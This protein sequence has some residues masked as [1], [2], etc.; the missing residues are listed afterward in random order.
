MALK[1]TVDTWKLKTWYSIIAPKFL[2]EAKVGDVPVIEDKNLINRTIAVP[3]KEVTKNLNHL[4]ISLKLR[5][6]EIRGKNAYTKF[7]GHEVAREG[8]KQLI[9]RGRDALEVV[10]DTTSKDGL[11][12][13]V[14]AVIVTQ[15][16]SS[17]KKKVELRKIIVEQL[18]KMTTS[19]DMGAFIMDCF[20]GKNASELYGISKKIVPIKKV[21]IRKTELKEVFDTEEDKKKEELKIAVE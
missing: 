18:K 1:K 19:K 15:M 9:R 21:E 13:R 3:L 14:K 17:K 16:N 12:F 20:S 11:D 4:N 5:I 7:I 6:T 8:I 2:N 10:I